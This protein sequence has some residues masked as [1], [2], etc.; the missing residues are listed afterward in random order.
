[1]EPC[2]FSNW[3]KLQH[4]KGKHQN[5]HRDEKMRPGEDCQE[6]VQGSVIGL[7]H[8]ANLANHHEGKNGVQQKGEQEQTNP[9]SGRFTPLPGGRSQSIYFL[10]AGE[11]T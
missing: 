6:Q 9:A 3:K 8:Q 11:P 10:Y 2:F 7:F 5:R 1:M 4:N